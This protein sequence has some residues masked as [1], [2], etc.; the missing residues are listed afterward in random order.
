MPST[1]P[2][3][4][5]PRDFWGCPVGVEERV[6]PESC[7]VPPHLSPWQGHQAAARSPPRPSPQAIAST[8]HQLWRHAY[9]PIASA[10][11]KRLAD[12]LPS[13]S[14]LE[15]SPDWA[16]RLG[17]AI[18]SATPWVWPHGH[19]LMSTGRTKPSPP[20]LGP[21]VLCCLP[22]LNYPIT[23]KTVRTHHPW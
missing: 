21:P 12:P 11:P 17:S 4:F 3:V 7:A 18:L 2:D 23:R 5:L 9:L 19:G 6:P 13:L 22:Q 20:V 10:H 15:H 14:L 16:A 8:S 1:P